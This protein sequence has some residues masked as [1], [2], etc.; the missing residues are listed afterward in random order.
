MYNHSI[1][2]KKK[3]LYILITLPLILVYILIGYYLNNIGNI[4]LIIYI[5]L[6]TITIIFQSYNCI[7]WKC[8]HVGTLCPGAGGFCVLSS[9]IG[10]LLI[11]MKIKSSEKLYKILCS[12]AFTGF[13]G[14]ILYPVYFIYKLSILYLAFYFFIIS[15][16]FLFM[17]ILICPDCGA[18]K[19]CP[20]GQFS[21]KIKKQC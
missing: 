12:I 10:K 7:Y 6:F 16:Y 15:A 19:A 9:P 4:N 2:Y 17:M 5:T 18:K 13:L 21:L 8:P 1:P 11:N 20:G 3:G 14:I